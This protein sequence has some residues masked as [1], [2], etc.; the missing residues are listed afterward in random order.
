MQLGSRTASV[1]VLL[2]IAAGGL[3]QARPDRSGRRPIG[4]DAG[5]GSV[6]RAT[7]DA[8][9]PAIRRC[10][11]RRRDCPRPQRR[12]PNRPASA[13]R[14]PLPWTRSA[15]TIARLDVVTTGGASRWRTDRPDSST[16]ARTRATAPSSPA[17]S[18]RPTR[19]S[20]PTATAASCWS[21]RGVTG[22][23]SATAIDPDWSAEP[24]STAR[25]RARP[26]T[27]WA[28][29]PLDDDH[30]RD[31]RR[32][33]RERRRRA[34]PP[35]G[36]TALGAGDA[37]AFQSGK[38]Y[39]I[40]AQ[41]DRV[42][43]AWG[44]ARVLRLAVLD[45]SGALVARPEQTGS[46]PPSAAETATAIPW[47]PACCCSTA[48]RVRADAD[49]IRSFAHG[50]RREPAAA[51]VLSD[52]APGRGRPAR[53]AAAD[54]LL[55][56]GVPG[57]RQQPGIHH[58]P[59]LRVRAGSRRVRLPAPRRHRSPPPGWAATGSR[60]NRWRRRRSRP[61]TRSR[62]RTPTSTGAAGCAS[63][64]S[65]ARSGPPRTLTGDAADQPAAERVRARPSA[66]AGSVPSGQLPVRHWTLSVQ[67]PPT[68]SCAA[69][70]MLAR[71]AERRRPRTRAPGR[72]RPRRSVC[73]PR[74][75]RWSR[76]RRRRRAQ[77]LD[78]SHDAPTPPER[79]ARA[80]LAVAAEAVVRVAE[81]AQVG[82]VAVSFRCRG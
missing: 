39:G 30:H 50:A 35:P 53:G 66:S 64:T 77:S 11:S 71:V 51:H 12:R 45:T 2:A 17:S 61:A 5:G 81:I 16:S 15:S 4:I 9:L 7:P 58:P 47:E 21:T 36:P 8:R 78:S 59:A 1:F 34:Q 75:G 24:A 10:R 48:T 68:S 23:F 27:C 20:S 42:L 26:N 31:H 69:Q 65:A 3:W 29:S 19:S 25:P 67:A 82:D 56:D 44:P 33:V 54:R 32:A 73:A 41:A 46:S 70:T 37:R 6:G 52:R 57:D 72:C 49:R 43:I 18:S 60:R 22:A 40:A 80:G 62:S 76:R 14:F 74:T 79:D 13:P 63:P 38:L 55:A 28:P